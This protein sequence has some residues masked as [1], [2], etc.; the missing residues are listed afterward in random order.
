MPF[1][2]LRRRSAVDE[3]GEM[4]QEVFGLAASAIEQ[5]VTETEISKHIKVSLYLCRVKD[6]TGTLR[7]K[8]WTDLAL[9]CRER[10]QS[11]RNARKQAL[12]LFL[13]GTRN[14]PP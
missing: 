14:S 12:H 11:F 3:H 13:P 10:F 6:C 8:V 4:K 2:R 7:P 1:C 9:R 5:F